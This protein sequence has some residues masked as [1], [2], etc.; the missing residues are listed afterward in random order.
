MQVQRRRSY[1]PLVAEAMTYRTLDAAFR[2]A[3]IDR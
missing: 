3:G 1:D 2:E